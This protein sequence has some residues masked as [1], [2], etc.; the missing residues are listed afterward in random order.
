MQKREQYKAK[1]TLRAAEEEATLSKGQLKRKRLRE[2]RKAEMAKLRAARSQE[3]QEARSD[4]GSAKGKKRLREDAVAA[5][6]KPDVVPRKGAAD[7]LP[8]AR[9]GDDSEDRSEDRSEKVQ[10]RND[11]R[12]FRA[13][14]APLGQ[15]RGTFGRHAAKHCHSDGWA[16]RRRLPSR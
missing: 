2:E 3:T 16:R 7:V 4:A 9:A 6:R 8:T 15:C 11:G 1:L 12:P 5:R 13:R 10:H 14:D